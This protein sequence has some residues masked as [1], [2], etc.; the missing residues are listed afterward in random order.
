MTKTPVGIRFNYFLIVFQ[1]KKIKIK[2]FV[3]EKNTS[4]FV[5]F[6]GFY[7]IHSSVICFCS[8]ELKDT[9]I[10]GLENYYEHLQLDLWPKMAEEVQDRGP[11]P[12]GQ[13]FSRHHI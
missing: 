9:L 4:Y 12:E 10:K 3:K 1:T 2:Q 7:F 8:E 6:C 13:Q 5:N 11:R